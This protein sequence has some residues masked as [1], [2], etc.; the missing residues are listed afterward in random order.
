[1]TRYSDS[2]LAGIIQD[3]HILSHT[4][5]LICTFSSTVRLPTGLTVTVVYLCIPVTP[6]VCRTAYELMQ[7]HHVDARFRF[8]SLDDIWFSGGQEE[9]LQEALLA[10]T[11]SGEGEV[12]LI[13]LD[14][15]DI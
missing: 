3:I 7:Q 10:H 4:D 11:P 12:T 15:I 2:S 6:Q 8:K 9:H 5:Y 13:G 1:M 14:D